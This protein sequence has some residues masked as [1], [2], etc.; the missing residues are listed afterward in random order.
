MDYINSTI[1]W[2][3]KNWLIIS[4]LSANII[5]LIKWLYTTYKTNTLGRASLASRRYIELYIPLNNLL[6]E[7]KTEAFVAYRG[8]QRYLLKKFIKELFSFFLL[9]SSKKEVFQKWND[10]KN[11]IL[12]GPT[13]DFPWATPDMDKIT[14]IFLDKRSIIPSELEDRWINVVA[15]SNERFD[16]SEEELDKAVAELII[17]IREITKET[18]NYLE[19]KYPLLLSQ[20]SE[21]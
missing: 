11:P 6:H 7:V 15:M 4:S 21:K 12:S 1:S 16:Y 10:F 17:Y 20:V 8:N 13:Y 18:R 9:Q 14:E 3:T 19:K 2:I 5:I